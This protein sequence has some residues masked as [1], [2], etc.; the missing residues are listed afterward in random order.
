MQVL[1]LAINFYIL[2]TF[3]LKK[4]RL[5]AFSDG[6][7]AIILTIMVLELHI[8]HNNSVDD[9]IMALKPILPVFLSYILSFINIG[10]YWNN[11]HHLFLIVNKIN[12]RVLWANNHLLFWL[13][14]IP[15]TTGWMGENHFASWPV[16]VYSFTLMMAG[17][18]Y[19]ILVKTLVGQDNLNKTLS[20]AVGK[21]KKGIVSVV[22][23]ALGVPI[24]FIHP[25]LG[26]AACIG[27][28]LIWLIPDK[29]IEKRLG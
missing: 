19:F 17:V 6:V 16:A 26:C 29:R 24:S 8:P 27:V 13:S 20:D 28:A 4:S 5:E 18:A 21:D 11:H 22:T 2:K 9:G 25:L 15:F 3:I 1:C 12:G 14:L 10:I 7:F 23:Y